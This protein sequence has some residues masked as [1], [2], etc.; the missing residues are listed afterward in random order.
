MF[1]SHEPPTPN[2]AGGIGYRANH[3]EAWCL[4]SITLGRQSYTEAE[5]IA[6]MQNP[7]RR[8]RT[9]QLAA[10]LAAAKLNVDCNLYGFKLG[11][12]CYRD[13]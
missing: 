3:P 10:Q 1:L 4:S 7:T 11:R 5:A 6:I 12:Q 2:G 13:R 8:D 9:Y